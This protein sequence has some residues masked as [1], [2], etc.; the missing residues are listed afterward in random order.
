MILFTMKIRQ[1][2]VFTGITFISF[3]AL[4][5]ESVED[6]WSSGLAEISRYELKQARYG[7]FYE[8]DAILLFVTEPFSPGAQVKDDS[9][10]DPK[11]ERI[12]KLNAF[13]RFTTGIYDYSIMTSVFSSMDFSKELPTHKVTSSVQDWCGQV[14]NQWNHRAQAGE[15]QIR[16][17][18]QSEGDVDASVPLFPHEDGIW[19]RLRMDPDSLPTGDL[20][21]IPSSVFLRLK[22]KPIQPYSAVANLSEA[23]WG[24]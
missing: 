3:S 4:R 10:K 17:Y 23:S 20:K 6:Y 8:G 24:K 22:H 1:L 19:N 7:A 14:F 2:W 18:F 21:M 13:K 9:G 5:G 15:Y 12:L 16:S 11:A